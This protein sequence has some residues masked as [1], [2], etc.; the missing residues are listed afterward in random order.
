MQLAGSAD[1]V[2]GQITAG[3]LLGMSPA[4]QSKA[5][6]ASTPPVTHAG[7]DRGMVWWHPDSP[8]F[9]L[10]GVGVLTILGLAGADVR[11]RLLGRRASA[12][13]GES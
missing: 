9:W 7:G 6:G 1:Y 10:I 2:N 13:V 5:A 3:A 4:N 8:D 12:S 11:V